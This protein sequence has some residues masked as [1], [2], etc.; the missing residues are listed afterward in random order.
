VLRR[1]P[2]L[3]EVARSATRSAP[4][5]V[6][7]E[8]DSTAALPR[9]VLD[10]LDTLHSMSCPVMSA[11]PQKSVSH[12]VIDTSLTGNAWPSPPS[13]VLSPVAEP[14]ALDIERCDAMRHDMCWD[15]VDIF[16]RTATSEA[17]SKRD[18]EESSWENEYAKRA[19]V[20]PLPRTVPPELAFS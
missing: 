6:G 7:L 11:G 18:A 5:G 2:R 16:R 3:F 20:V 9:L 13:S 19:P 14:G 1:A 17:M 10:A 15:A 4:D 12:V 8:V